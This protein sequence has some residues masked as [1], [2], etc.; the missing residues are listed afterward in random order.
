LRFAGALEGDVN[1]CPP[2]ARF[3][4][5]HPSSLQANSEQ[6]LTKSLRLY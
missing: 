1:A 3:G 5:A 2:Q 6:S 4:S